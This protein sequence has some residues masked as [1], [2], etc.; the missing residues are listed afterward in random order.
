[1]FATARMFPNSQLCRP[2]EASDYAEYSRFAATLRPT[3]RAA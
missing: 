2:I 3:L 1:M